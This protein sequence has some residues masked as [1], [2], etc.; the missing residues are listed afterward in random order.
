MGKDALHE[1]SDVTRYAPENARPLTPEQFAR[2]RGAGRNTGARGVGGGGRG[3]SGEYTRLV[4]EAGE[5]GDVEGEMVARVTFDPPIQL[6]REND[7]EMRY[8]IR[9]FESGA[10]RDTDVSKFDYE[11]FFSP[12]VLQ[13]FAAYMD[14]HRILPDG[15]T[16]DSDNWQKGIPLDAYMKSAWR[17]FM[18]WWLLHRGHEAVRPEDGTHINLIEALCAVLFNVQGYLHELLKDE[19]ARRGKGTAVGPAHPE[20]D[21]GVSSA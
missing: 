8:D 19:E 11:G 7:F 20:S 2:E 16:R 17:H 12:L 1:A 3:V 18:D 10:S 9:T 6:T 15:S 4:T 14:S 5:R 21:G 13:E